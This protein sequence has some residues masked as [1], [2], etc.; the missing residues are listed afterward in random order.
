ML[1]WVL[2]ELLHATRLKARLDLIYE[3]KTD[4]WGRKF[5]GLH[6]TVLPLCGTARSIFQQLRG[7]R[8]KRG[9]DVSSSANIQGRPNGRLTGVDMRHILLLLPFL[10]FDLHHHEVCEYNRRHD[11]HHVSPAQKL[12]SWV[13]VLLEWYRLYR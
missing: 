1:C 8:S 2:S 11:T 10:L 13:L 5:S 12:I 7:K 3:I 6:E 4:K 9:R